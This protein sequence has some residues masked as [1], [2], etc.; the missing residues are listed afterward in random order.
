[1]ARAE[2]ARAEQAAAEANQGVTV[3]EARVEDR[4]RTADAVDPDVNTR[5]DDYRPTEPGTHAATDR[6]DVSAHTTGTTTG[7]TTG[8]TIL[9]PQREDTRYRS[10]PA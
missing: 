6:D 10:D 3:E 8:E 9:E 4:L 5:T 7:E 1:M 2:A